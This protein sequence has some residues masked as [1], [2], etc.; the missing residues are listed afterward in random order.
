MVKKPTKPGFYKYRLL[1]VNG[2]KPGDWQYCEIVWGEEHV[3][4]VVH[5]EDHEKSKPLSQYANL[6]E[7]ERT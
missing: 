1:Y 5:N 3:L 7:W 2:S 4:H 6:I